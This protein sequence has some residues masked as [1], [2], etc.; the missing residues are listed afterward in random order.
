[1]IWIFVELAAGSLVLLAAQLL[2]YVVDARS[3]RQQVRPLGA[4]TDVPPSVK[5][6]AEGEIS[7]WY[8]QAA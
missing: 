1:M 4:F 7:A 3:I 5:H 6:P 8:D 2:E